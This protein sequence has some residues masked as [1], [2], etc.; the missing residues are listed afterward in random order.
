MTGVI[1]TALIDVPREGVVQ[2]RSEQTTEVLSANADFLS[3]IFEKEIPGEIR[4]HILKSPLQSPRRLRYAIRQSGRSDAPGVRSSMDT[5]LALPEHPDKLCCFYRLEKVGISVQ[6]D[7]N[8][9]V[10]ELIIR[11]E[12]HDAGWVAFLPQGICRLETVLLG[13]LDIHENEVRSELLNTLD[14]FDAVRCFAHDLYLWHF[15]LESDANR[16]T[17]EFLVVD[18]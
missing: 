17:A 2:L 13:H 11:R 10:L 3:D 15:T 1:D 18:E 4:I 6:C 5:A 14:R 16:P 7:G 8:P 12:E 9:S